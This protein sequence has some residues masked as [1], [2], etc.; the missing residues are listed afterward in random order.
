MSVPVTFNGVVYPIPVQGDIGWGPALTRYLVAIA[1]GAITPSG[2]SYPLTADLNFGSSFG[3]VAPYY[4]SSSANISTAGVLRLS[5]TDS[6]GWRNFANSGNLLLGVNTSDQLTFGGTPIQPALTLLDGQI[7]IGNSS[8]LPIGRILS[9]GVTVTD[10]GV[11]S[12]SANYITNTM[13]NSAAAIAYS[14]LNLSGSILNS[15]IFSSAAIAYSKLNLA[16]SIVNADI[17]SAAAIS[18]SKLSLTASIVNA[19]VAA[20]AAI[21]YTKLAAL[22]TSIVP[23]T[24]GSG[25]LTSSTTTTTQLGFLDAT[26]S[27]QTQLNSKQATGNYITALTGDVTAVGPGSVAATL[28]TV[29]SN[30]GS[31]G[32]STSIPSF[33]VNGKGL[34]TAASGN[35]VIAPAGTLSGTTLNSTVV[36]S[37]LTTVGTI[38]SGVWNGTAITVPNGGTGNTSLTAYAV[39]TGGTTSTSPV[40][41]IASVG[42]AGQVLTSNGAGALPTFQTATGTGTVNSGTAGNVAYYATSTNAVSTTAAF[43]VGATGPNGIIVGTNTN[44]SAAAG[45]VGEYI[46]AAAA[47]TNFPASATFGDLTSISLTAGD[48]DVGV[49]GQVNNNSAVPTG[50]YL[51]GAS[52][53][54][55]NSGTGLTDGTTDL[56]LQGFFTG[57]NIIP[58]SLPRIRFSLSSTTTVYLKY[59]ATYTGGPPKAAGSLTARRIR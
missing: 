32:S 9:G 33:T 59:Y 44:N 57:T 58:V 8:N 5:N 4:K 16:N 40:Q 19:D 29:N 49:I 7:W 31:F 15:D 46:D 50:L 22:N 39:L 1:S 43:T 51:I 17:N 23:V 38:T 41:S 18:Y 2:G 47:A 10:T 54:S 28:A 3:L 55:G 56:S 52:I 30:V 53:N 45:V 35:A 27:I 12:I 21:A 11:T 20:A 36:L 14:K 25:F 34:I 37:S 13:V 48:W 26:S 6:I 42:T 24:N